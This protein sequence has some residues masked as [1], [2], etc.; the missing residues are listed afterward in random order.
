[1]TAGGGDRRSSGGR[2]PARF[3]VPKCKACP[4]PK[5]CPRPPP[6]PKPKPC[7]RSNGLTC[8][9]FRSSSACKPYNSRTIDTATGPKE[10][11]YRDS[12]TANAPAGATFSN[13]ASHVILAGNL[14]AYGFA[15]ASDG[16]SNYAVT[17][18]LAVTAAG[19]KI[20]SVAASIFNNALVLDVTIDC[21]GQYLVAP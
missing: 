15:Q 1:M 5:A 3:R 16:R 13:L 19:C 17:T 7:P 4:K 8:A 6:C 10:G 21:S 12:S 11:Q 9:N 14:G 2:N 20:S 18:S